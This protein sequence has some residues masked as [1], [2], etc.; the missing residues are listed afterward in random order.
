MAAAQRNGVNVPRDAVRVA[1]DR[2]VQLPREQGSGL[3]WNGFRLSR[4]HSMKQPTIAASWQALHSADSCQTNTPPPQISLNTHTA[5]VENTRTTGWTD[6]ARI[7]PSPPRTARTR[8]PV[9]APPLPLLGEGEDGGGGGGR[10]VGGEREVGAGQ[11]GS[12]GGGGRERG[13]GSRR[14]PTQKKKQKP[15]AKQLCKPDGDQGRSKNI[16]VR[17][18]GREVTTRPMPMPAHNWAGISPKERDKKA[19][20]P[21]GKRHPQALNP[22]LGV[23]I[24]Q[25]IG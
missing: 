18:P 14:N 3:N 25:L 11:V 8:G 13:R 5:A 2:P 17:P 6:E 9:P 12:R 15:V 1:A 20:P 22:M 10:G 7:S 4:K 16:K 19:T 21:R 23:I 24:A